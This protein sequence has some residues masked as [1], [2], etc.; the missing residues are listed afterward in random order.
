MCPPYQSGRVQ[1]GAGVVHQVCQSTAVQR[2]TDSN[3]LLSKIVKTITFSSVSLC[4]INQKIE[5]Y[6]C[7]TIL[8][9]C[10]I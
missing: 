1:G 7:K 10:I 5:T 8:Q 3:I 9:Q 4:V 6:L 2:V